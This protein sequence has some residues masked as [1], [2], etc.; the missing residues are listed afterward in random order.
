[1]YVLQGMHMCNGEAGVHYQ[2]FLSHAP[3]YCLRWGLLLS[4]EITDLATVLGQQVADVLAKT[5]E[6]ATLHRSLTQCKRSK[7]LGVAIS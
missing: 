1:M 6:T 2:V 3:P 4:L 5:R 7:G